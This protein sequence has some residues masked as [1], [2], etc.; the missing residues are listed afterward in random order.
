MT[1]FFF[2]SGMIVAVFRQSGMMDF[3][4]DR[5]KIFVKTSESWSACF[6]S[7][8][9]LTTSGLAAF[10]RFTALSIHLTSCSRTVRMWLL[11]GGGVVSVFIA[12][13]SK[14]GKE[15][16]M[17]LCQQ[18][19][20][21]DSCADAGLVVCDVLNALPHPLWVVIGDVV[22]NLRLVSCFSLHDA[23]LQVGS[24]SAV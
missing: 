10:L 21:V 16:I 18:G 23:S 2:G 12:F 4:R 9:P 5:L 20:T 24:S 3:N 14:S 11:E 22:F 6:F 15:T 8:L 19:V 1:V 7:T 13:I 17:F